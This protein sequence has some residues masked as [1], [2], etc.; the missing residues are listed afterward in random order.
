MFPPPDSATPPDLAARLKQL[1][2]DAG[3]DLAGIARAAPTRYDQQYRDWIAAGKH[4][5][6]RYLEKN[7]D[8]RL[9]ITRKFPWAKSILCVALAYFQ[10]PPD[11]A[12][13]AFAAPDA[14]KIAKYAWGRDYHKVIDAKLKTVEQQ[15]RAL[16]A[17]QDFHARAYSDTGPLLER[18]LAQR[19]GLGWVGKHTLLLHPRH[20]SYFLLGELVLSLDLP[21][22]TPITDHCGTCTRCIDSCPTAAITPYS[23][24][25]VKCIS[26]QTLE[27]RGDIPAKFHAPMQAA[28]FL[29]GCDICQDVC[30][31]NRRPL[32]TSEPDFTAAP[33]PLLS[34][35]DV[36]EWSE[37]D[38]DCATRGRAF[39][40]TKHDML[41]RNAALLTQTPAAP[42]TPPDA[43]AGSSTAPPHSTPAPA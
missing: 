21:P 16:L 32:P 17:P 23:V 31:F 3:F 1:A 12:A 7:I 4:G 34:P 33:V 28:N 22:D 14:A 43:S 13:P 30:P 11:H 26:Y 41:Q 38:W 8:E 29:V 5:E 37:Q 2:L 6:M 39:R 36:L 19:A 35:N 15:L 10:Q 20:G 42:V 24:D 9:D 18:E 25:A 40:R 27:N